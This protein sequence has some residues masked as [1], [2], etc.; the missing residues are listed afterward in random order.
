MGGFGSGRRSYDGSRRNTDECRCLDIR[1]WQR[2]GILMPGQAFCWQWLR[3]EER[4]AS[5][6]V[7]TESDRIILSYKHRRDGKDWKSE[8]YS[9]FLDWTDCTYGGRRPWFLCPSSQCGRR[10]AILYSG[11]AIFACRHCYR[12]AYRSQRETEL[13]CVVRRAERIRTRLGW[14]IG[15]LNERG[16]KPKRMRWRTFLRL[17][18]EHDAL[19]ADALQKMASKLRFC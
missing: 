2:D 14:E 12:L 7:R 19:V 3:G 9:V 16:D 6:D 8:E 13:D 4:T 11:G 15:I 17:C 18:A 10:V 1:R 5:I